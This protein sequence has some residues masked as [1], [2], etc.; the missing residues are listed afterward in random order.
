VVPTSAYNTKKRG[1]A[2]FRSLQ[3]QQYQ[4][5]ASTGLLGRCMTRYTTDTRN[6]IVEAHCEHRREVLHN[7]HRSKTDS[8]ASEIVASGT[9]QC[10]RV[11]DEDFRDEA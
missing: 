10:S 4:R 11:M 9:Q 8:G 1:T 6:E 3:H 7:K 2:E 5:T